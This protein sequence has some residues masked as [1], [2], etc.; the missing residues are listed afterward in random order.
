MKTRIII[1]ATACVM[2]F[3]Y[4][5]L[6]E[7]PKSNERGRKNYAVLHNSKI[8]GRLNYIDHS[9][10][11]T[12]SFSIK[13]DSNYYYGLFSFLGEE[14]HM[15]LQD[16]AKEGDS[17]IKDKYSDTLTLIKNGKKYYYEIRGRPSK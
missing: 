12:Y 5:F 9:P 2:F 10:A 14:K 6:Y 15:E 1:P 8:N 16:F 13:D 3:L 4:H 7:R 11:F 17:I